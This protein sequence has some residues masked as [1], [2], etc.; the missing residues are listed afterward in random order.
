MAATESTRE[1]ALSRDIGLRDV[2]MIGIGAMIG[3]GIFVLTGIAAGQAGPALILVFVLN[4]IIALLTALPYAELGSCFPQAG[5]GYQ[6][7]SEA[8]PEPAGF[9]TGW[10]SWFGHSVACSLY[11]LGFGAYLGEILSDIIVH[12]PLQGA[13]LTVVLAHPWFAKLAAVLCCALFTYINYRGASETGKAETLVTV[14]KLIVLG[15]FVFSG[16][17][18]IAHKPNWMQHFRPFFPTGWKGIVSAMGLTYIAFQGYEIIAQSGEEVVN[19]RRNV[20]LAIIISI[21]VVIPI[22]CLVAFVCIGA[23]TPPSGQPTWQ[24]LGDMGELGVVEAAR[25]FMVGGGF[26]GGLILTLGGLLATVSALNATVYSS[27]RV[28]F[29]MGRDRKFPGAFAAVH[30]RRRTPHVAVIVSGTLI[31]LMAVSLPIKDVASAADVMFLMLF[32]LVN[33]S[34]IILRKRRP[35]LDR[36]FRVP[37]MPYIPAVAAI[38]SLALTAVL[39]ADSPKATI[40]TAIWL[41]IGLTVY[42]VYTSR[43]IE[44]K[45]P[46]APIVLER[47][48]VQPSGYRALVPVARPDHVED[49][50]LVGSALA[51]HNDGE[52]DALNVIVVPNI[53]PLE[54]ALRFQDPAERILEQA[55]KSAETYGV[56]V[57]TLARVGH[58]AEQA[59]L[60]T[61]RD[62]GVNL[63]V[64]GWRGWTGAQGRVMG[65]VL[66]PVV[67]KAP[68]DLA[69]VKMMGPLSEV[70]R[71][72]AGVTGSPQA[73]LTV[74]VAKA[75]ASLTGADVDFIH[76]YRPGEEDPS[77]VIERFRNMQDPALRVDVQARPSASPSTGL[78]N[79]AD[80][81]DLLILGAAREGLLQQLFFGVNT[82]TVA[83]AVRC[84]VI[85]VRQRESAARAAVREIL[86]PL[87]E[88]ERRHID[89]GDET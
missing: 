84:S 30:P 40:V 63:T 11:A 89:Y 35:D 36:R 6:W 9:L 5:G 27:S 60:D 55:R 20:P 23:I 42:R 2:T 71:I 87:P 72:L 56:P 41:G 24:V 14:G 76:F 73:R 39:F 48:P 50:M 37:L 33:I 68:S 77:A 70:K 1:V 45:K 79:A 67:G 19:P 53:L 62:Y 88:E 80:G 51:R 47:A 46:K 83:N 18:V 69:V 21:L 75:V 32:A 57:R 4:G 38:A 31:A 34:A 12:S 25:Q 78:I 81:Y 16:L 17:Y 49:L 52:V 13:G 44:E 3:A 29:A 74:H 64:L 66:D 22:Y 85:M 86:S 15:L 26:I 43:R 61:I 82:R 54:E 58:K 8:L 28:S 59:I 10:V 7:V 65:A